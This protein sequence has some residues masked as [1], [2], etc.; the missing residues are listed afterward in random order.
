MKFGNLGYLNVFAKCIPSPRAF[1][2]G[3]ELHDP[4]VEMLTCS[5]FIG[6]PLDIHF[7]ESHSR[8]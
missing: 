7:D 1:S 2:Q 3:L 8:Q 6:Y 4:Y 5:S